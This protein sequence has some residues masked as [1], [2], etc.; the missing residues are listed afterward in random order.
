MSAMGDMIMTGIKG[1]MDSTLFIPE[2]ESAVTRDIYHHTVK[3]FVSVR[4]MG[5]GILLVSDA[6]V[7]T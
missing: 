7:V 2:L 3:L 5:T 1:M 4:Q 6:W